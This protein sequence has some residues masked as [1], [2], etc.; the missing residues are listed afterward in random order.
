MAT[1]VKYRDT[2]PNRSCYAVQTNA[3]GAPSGTDGMD[4]GGIAGFTLYASCEEGQ[5][6]NDAAA[7]FEAW[8]YDATVGVWSRA[9]ELDVTVG[10]SQT[11]VRS[12]AVA[13]SV[14]SP[15]GYIAHIWDGS[16]VTGGNVTVAYAASRLIGEKG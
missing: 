5:T 4:L 7:V 16:G 11:G 10:A 1:W 2:H 6:F 14:A 8:R 9:A 12:L 15:R 3:E 13:F